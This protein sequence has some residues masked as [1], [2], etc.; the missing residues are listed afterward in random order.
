MFVA[1]SQ[2]VMID[3]VTGERRDALDQRWTPFLRE[4]GLSPLLVPNHV[5]TARQLMQLNIICGVL[6]TGG[7]DLA[8]YGG[9]APERD[10]TERFLIEEAGRTSQPVLGVC[11]GMQMLQHHAGVV[12]KR[13]DGHVAVRHAVQLPD[14]P[15]N[16]N[17]FH[18]WGATTTVTGLE[19]CAATTDGV[20]E[21][22]IDRPRRRAGIMW[23]PERE[24]PFGP[25]DVNF[26]RQFFT[27]KRVW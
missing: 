22:I 25:R 12:L 1:V 2:R 11:R 6:L 27:G 15:A 26:V 17:S 3:P 20:I 8:A 24:T 23:H 16:V 7:N 5:E 13:V 19:I 10:E 4:C 9:D 18:G 14:G 21:A